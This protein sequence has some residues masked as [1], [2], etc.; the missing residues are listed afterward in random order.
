MHPYGHELC[1]NNC[2]FL[3]CCPSWGAFSNGVS[4][5]QGGSLN[6][7]WLRSSQV[8]SARGPVALAGI[9][10]EDECTAA[11]ESRMT[12][13]MAAAVQRATLALVPWLLQHSAGGQAQVL[14][15]LQ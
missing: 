5:A 13:F 12:E 3:S 9:H 11:V 4:R 10:V 7:H 1:E 15:C 14:A 2:F 6:E 8:Y